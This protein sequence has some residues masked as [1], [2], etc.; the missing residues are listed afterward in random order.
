MAGGVVAILFSGIQPSKLI[1]TVDLSLLLF[2]CGL[3]IVIG[4]A[5]QAGVLDN[6]RIHY[7]FKLTLQV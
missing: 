3:F 6:L 1:R 7:M 5:K 2:F 4:G